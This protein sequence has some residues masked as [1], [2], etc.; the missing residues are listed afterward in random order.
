MRDDLMAGE[1]APQSW[2]RRSTSLAAR[3]GSVALPLSP[4]HA[5]SSWLSIVG[6]Y[7]RGAVRQEEA[8]RRAT[9]LLAELAGLAPA[10]RRWAG[11]RPMRSPG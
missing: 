9:A 10:R 1:A 5:I 4:P 7:G 3:P 2:T 6:A 11:S 8:D